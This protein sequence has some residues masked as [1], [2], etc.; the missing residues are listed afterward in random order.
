[1]QYYYDP[2]GYQYDRRN[3]VLEA[4]EQMKRQ[5]TSYIFKYIQL[6]AQK[7]K[8]YIQLAFFYQLL[9]LIND[10]LYENT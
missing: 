1:M 6:V 10:N 5:G 9:S 2:S 7:K 4:Y 3:D 8:K